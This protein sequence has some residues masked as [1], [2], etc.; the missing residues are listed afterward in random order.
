MDEALEK[1]EIDFVEDFAAK[2]TVGLIASICGVPREHWPF[3]R[4]MTLDISR[5]YG[6]APFF[7]EPQPEIEA[8]IANYGKAMN[9]FIAEHVN[10]LRRTNTPSILTEIGKSIKDDAM[11]A[12]VGAIILGAGNETTANL[13]TNSLYE[14]IHH[15]AQFDAPG[16]SIAS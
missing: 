8:R 15:P 10:Y 5:D 3:I 11:F 4:R 7:R 9:E 6:K 16:T 13:I 14:L 1:S 2:V 12:A